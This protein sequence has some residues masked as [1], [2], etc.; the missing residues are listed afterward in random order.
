LRRCAR[1]RFTS[2]RRTARAAADG[3]V[4]WLHVIR[5]RRAVRRALP[6]GTALHV[7]VGLA[8]GFG[9]PPDKCYVMLNGVLW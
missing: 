3:E 6:A 8:R 9:E 1:Q 4:D 5:D 7:R 2:S